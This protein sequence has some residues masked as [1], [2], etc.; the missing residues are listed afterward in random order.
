[1][2]DTQ[3]SLFDDAGEPVVPASTR[4]SL[5]FVTASSADLASLTEQ[6]CKLLELLKNRWLATAEIVA[7]VG[8]TDALRR[9]RELRAHGFDI[10]M[11]GE[12]RKW[13]YR[14]TGRVRDGQSC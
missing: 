10:E 4:E 5:G 7:A 1:M 6:K 9:V 11:R 2:C 14:W 13:L 3:F 12:G 8:A